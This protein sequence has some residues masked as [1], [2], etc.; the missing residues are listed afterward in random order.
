MDNI[1]KDVTGIAMA[2]VG[3]AILY[4]LVNPQNKTAQVIGALGNAFG[5]SLSA[6]MGQGGNR[7][8][9]TY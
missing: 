5:G 2:I 3:V 8:G 6:A 4:T 1:V 9:G 7:I